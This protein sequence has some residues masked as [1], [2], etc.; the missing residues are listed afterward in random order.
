MFNK[1]F[2]NPAIYEIMWNNIVEP[3]RPQMTTWCKCFAYWIPKSINTHSEYVTR[4]AFPLQQWLYEHTSMLH[5][6][7]I[8]CLVLISM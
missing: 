5:C 6:M 2:R 7:F 3:S 1:F 4:I 8:A